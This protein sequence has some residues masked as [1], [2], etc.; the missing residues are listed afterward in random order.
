MPAQPHS[1]PQTPAFHHKPFVWLRNKLLAGV[2]LALP[3]VVTFWILQSVYDLLKGWSE[4]MLEF[5][6]VNVNLVAGGHVIDLESNAFH[7]VSKFVGVLIPLLVFVFLGVMATNVIGARIVTAMDQLMLRVPVISFIYKT[8]KQ[9][10]D[11]FKG[12]GAKQNF[13]RVVYVDYPAAGMKMLGFVT[14]QFYDTDTGRDMTAVFVPGALSVMTGL[15][16]VV[17][18]EKLTDAPL[19]IEDAMKLVF[20]GGLV[21]PGEGR[22]VARPAA[23][24]LGETAVTPEP[25]EAQL[26]KDL[27]PNLPRAEDFDFGDPDILASSDDIRVPLLTAAG[28]KARSWGL[29]LPWGRRG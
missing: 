2:A 21:V 6:A 19:S 24:P 20:S 8:L 10:I 11:A 26:A 15:L 12:F 9:V 1:A 29:L 23:A 16:L 25:A 7:Q 17:E 4:P 28:R 3:L 18:T 27:P 13:K 22:T 14:G 5:V